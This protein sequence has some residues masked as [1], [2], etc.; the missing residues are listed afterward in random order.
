MWSLAAGVPIRCFFWYFQ[1]FFFQSKPY[2]IKAGSRCSRPRVPLS[3]LRIDQKRLVKD[4]AKDDHWSA[5]KVVRESFANRVC[6]SMLFLRKIMTWH[7]C[8]KISGQ[9]SRSFCCTLYTVAGVA[10]PC[11]VENNESGKIRESSPCMYRKNIPPLKLGT[12]VNLRRQDCPN[13]QE[14]GAKEGNVLVFACVFALQNRT[15]RYSI[16]RKWPREPAGERFAKDHLFFCEKW[17]FCLEKIDQSSG[18]GLLEVGH[19]TGATFEPPVDCM[20]IFHGIPL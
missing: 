4:L 18:V 10:L 3:Q 16:L 7:E 13:G 5:P 20:T 11:S 14:V 12:T 1:I 6:E 17:P 19:C 15:T 2:S 9:H 8:R